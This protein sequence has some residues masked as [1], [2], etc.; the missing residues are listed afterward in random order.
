MATIFCSQK[1][2]IFLGLPTKPKVNT[3][4][5]AVPYGWNAMLFYLNKRKCLL[6][7]YKK[8]LYAFLVL[9]IVKKDLADF[10]KFFRLHLIDQLISDQL[11]NPETKT[12]LDVAYESITLQPTDNDKRVIG[13]MND[14]I[15]R[16]KVYD[17][18]TDDA[19]LLRSTY[20]GHQ[21]NKTPMGAISYDYPVKRMKEFLEELIS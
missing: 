17:S 1:L 3:T 13:S 7:M 15:Y 2:T 21:L 10:P 9:G 20:I 6:F 5:A 8:T 14:C 19:L 18:L 12:I 11:I 4:A 16:I